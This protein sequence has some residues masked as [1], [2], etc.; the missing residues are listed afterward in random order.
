MPGVELLQ[1]VITPALT[2]PTDMTFYSSRILCAS[3]NKYGSNDYR[4]SSTFAYAILSPASATG[5]TLRASSGVFY[6]GT[7][8]YM[9]QVTDANGC[10]KNCIPY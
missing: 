3:F 4:W 6:I 9:F 5:N 1:A 10:T 8:D 2:P 7:G